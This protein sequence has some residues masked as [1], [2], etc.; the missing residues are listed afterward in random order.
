MR[1]TALQAQRSFEALDLLGQLSLA[2]REG[3]ARADASEHPFGGRRRNIRCCQRKYCGYGR[4]WV[5][6]FTRSC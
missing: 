2:D 5:G 4:W 3:E 1:I 6:S